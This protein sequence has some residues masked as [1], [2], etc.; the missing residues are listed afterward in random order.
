[1]TKKKEDIYFTIHLLKFIHF[2]STTKNKM[3]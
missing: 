3:L 1:M 2:T